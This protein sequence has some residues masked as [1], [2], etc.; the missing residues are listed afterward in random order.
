[1]SL[2]PADRDDQL[3]TSGLPGAESE[4]GANRKT[5][6]ESG[7]QP[8]L[9]RELK[10]LVGATLGR[11]LASSAQR[12]ME[13][14]VRVQ[15]RCLPLTPVRV[16]RCNACGVASRDW[17]SVCGVHGSSVSG[18]LA[19]SFRAGGM[20][21]RFVCVCWVVKGEE[22]RPVVG[23]LALMVVRRCPTLPH[24]PGCSTIGAVGLSFRV[25]NGTGRFPHAMTAVTLL[26]VPLRPV[27]FR[28][29]EVFCYNCGVVM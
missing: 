20:L 3:C 9:T 23:A 19:G 2:G 22:P 15:Q 21:D 26:P 18:A 1:M 28:G 13:F 17:P 16:P 6:A 24:P 25:R 29:W 5:W 14:A 12:S 11:F 27:W 8:R 10:Q 4:A 7:H